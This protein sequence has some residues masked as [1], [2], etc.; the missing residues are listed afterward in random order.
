MSLKLFHLPAKKNVDTVLEEYANYKKSRGNTDNNKWV[1]LCLLSYI[2]LK[3]WEA[4]TGIFI[5]ISREAWPFSGAPFLLVLLAMVRIAFLKIEN[6]YWQLEMLEKDWPIRVDNRWPFLESVP[7]LNLGWMV[8]LE[9]KNK[10]DVYLLFLKET[11]MLGT[12][13]S[14]ESI[15]VSNDNISFQ[16]SFIRTKISV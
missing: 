6:V 10:M 7:H 5:G 15:W 16:C 8:L 13:S 4:N 12:F 1:Y 2:T 11:K 9:N 14:P 3:Y